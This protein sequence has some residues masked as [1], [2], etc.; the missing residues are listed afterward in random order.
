MLWLCFAL[1]SLA[2]L[3]IMVWPLLVRPVAAAG[4]S[5]H[6]LAVYRDQLAEIERDRSR[7][8]L[9]ERQFEDAKLEIQRRILSSA[10]T[11]E[12]FDALPSDRRRPWRLAAALLLLLPAGGF[13]L[14]GVT[15]HPSLPG[16]PFAGRESDP[17]FQAEQMAAHVEAEMR[18]APSARGFKILGD[19][20]A[21][22]GN[23]ERAV[24]AY[25]RSVALGGEE[26]ETFS[27]LG[28][29][30]AMINDGAVIP[31]ARSDFLRAL[32]LDRGD[33]RARFYLGLAE[34]QIGDNRKA[35]AI[36]RDLERDSDSEAPWLGML[37]E[38]IAVF[39]RQGGFS[40]DSVA[41]QPVK[42]DG[43]PSGPMADRMRAAAPDDQLQMIRSMVAGLAAKLEANPADL[44]GWLRLARSYK[45]LGETE[46]SAQA[47]KRAAALIKAMPPSSAR[48]EAQTV[49]DSLPE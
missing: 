20:R 23:Y 30:V 46:K 22:Q 31:E 11:A 26:A 9:D 17:V 4:P 49:L 33:P 34:A 35:V 39:S 28:E 43:A 16:R 7:N 5:T 27:S 18:Q 36:W 25:R 19:L 24:A 13:A 44:D 8:L 40:P 3:A 41:A 29:S 6:D 1:I 42:P 10:V 14:Y 45:V 37:R 48:T 12:A 21:E 47:A 15:G 32:E 2:V 38:H